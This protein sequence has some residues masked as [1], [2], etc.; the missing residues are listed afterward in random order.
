MDQDIAK[1]KTDTEQLEKK[2]D[3]VLLAIVAIKS[4][5]D[6]TLVAKTAAKVVIDGVSVESCVIKQNV[7]AVAR[8][9]SCNKN[10]GSA[11]KTNLGAGVC[12]SSGKSLNN[13]TWQ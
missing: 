7:D 9:Y 4:V 3:T 11:I 1:V 2:H 12:D 5:F 10:Y 8:K 13:G 6:Q